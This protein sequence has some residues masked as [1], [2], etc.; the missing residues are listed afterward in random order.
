M[1]CMTSLV[2][3]TQ[4]IGWLLSLLKLPCSAFNE[5]QS[6]SAPVPFR[7]GE[8]NN[9]CF[10]WLALQSRDPLTC[11]HSILHNENLFQFSLMLATIKQK[12]KKETAKIRYYI[13]TAPT[14]R[15][16]LINHKN[17]F[18]TKHP[19]K[20]GYCFKAYNP[21]CKPSKVHSYSHSNSQNLNYLCFSWSNNQKTD[22]EELHTRSFT[23]LSQE[24]EV[25]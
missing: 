11:T 2:K 21:M 7:V 4:D 3:T 9:T 15:E 18:A 13:P 5:L 25:S 20:L 14:K 1:I 17:I 16:K 19:K 8:G 10:V 24:S 6:H 12:Q 22:I 23:Y